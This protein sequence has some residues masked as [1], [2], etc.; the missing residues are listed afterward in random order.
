MGFIATYPLTDTTVVRWAVWRELSGDTGNVLD[1]VINGSVPLDTGWHDDFTKF[2]EEAAELFSQVR[3][4]RD[5]SSLALAFISDSPR[6]VILRICNS[7][8]NHLK[9]NLTVERAEQMIDELLFAC[10][11]SPLDVQPGEYASLT[12][13]C[14]YAHDFVEVSNI[15][16]ATMEMTALEN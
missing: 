5:G 13:L 14:I 8:L 10:E 7:Y 2:L 11:V 12:T 4:Y 1:R 15:M 3:I 16:G 9:S 6:K